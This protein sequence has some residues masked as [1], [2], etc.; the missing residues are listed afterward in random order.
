MTDE[1]RVVVSR[2]VDSIGS[3]LV[4]I[5]TYIFVPIALG[6]LFIDYRLTLAIGFVGVSFIGVR[7]YLGRRPSIA[8]D[9]AK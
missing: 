3:C 9:D 1:D 5:C 8:A 4:E 7:R 2:T 6:A